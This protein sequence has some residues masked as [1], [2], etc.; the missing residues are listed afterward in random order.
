MSRPTET[1]HLGR[2]TTMT[3]RTRRLGLVVALALGAALLAPATVSAVPVGTPKIGWSAR[4][5]PSPA[6]PTPSTWTGT[7]YVQTPDGNSR[8]HVE[9]RRRQRPRPGAGTFQYPGPGPVRH[10]GPDGRRQPDEHP[11][12]GDLD[13]LPGPGRA[14][15]RDRRRR[16]P[17]HDRGRRV[18]AGP[19]ATASPPAARART[20]TRAA[21]TSP[22]RSRW[23]CTAP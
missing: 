18:A 7:G 6:A 13:R 22:S 15:D 5:D 1:A 17:V 9:L 2:K 4:R 20:S 23:A 10:P 12:R 14:G 11:A 19:S 21:R 16:R 8:L 3:L